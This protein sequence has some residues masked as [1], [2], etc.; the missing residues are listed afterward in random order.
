M[1]PLTPEPF[2][3]RHAA[4][5]ALALLTAPLP[6]LA[7]LPKDC[8]TGSPDRAVRV[9]SKILDTASTS[10]ADRADAFYNRGNAYAAK[11]DHD[12]AIADYTAALEINARFANAAYNRGNSHAAKGEHDL[13][14]ADYSLMIELNPGYVNAYFNR[15]NSHAA[16]GQHEKA[17]ADYGKTVELDPAYLNAW[18]NR[19]NSFAAIGEHERA[20]EDYSKVVALDARSTNAWFNR[21]NSYAALGQH[22]QAIADYD[23]TVRLARNY[24]YAYFNRGNSHAELGDYDKAIAD[25]NRA[26]RLAPKS[27]RIF[28]KRGIAYAETDKK[29]KAIADF[30]KAVALAAP[31]DVSSGEAVK[32]IADLETGTK[33]AEATPEAAKPDVDAAAAVS[34]EATTDT[35]STQTTPGAAIDPAVFGRRVAL[36]IG[37]SAYRTVAALPNAVA[38]A[39]LTAK[40]LRAA[41]FAE[42]TVVKDLD[43]ESLIAAL[44]DFRSR[45]DEADWAVVYYA[46]HG[47]EVAGQNF[48]IP[49]DAALKDQRDVEDEAVNLNRVLASV[50]GARKLRL[51]ALD[52]CRDNPFVARMT[53]TGGT[54]SIG[55]GLARVE[56]EGATV[57]LFAAKEGTTAADGDDGN[58]PFAQAFAT[59]IVEPGVEIS[60]ALRRLSDDVYKNTEQKQEPVQYG[61]LPV[62]ELYFVPKS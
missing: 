32:R 12:R 51:V 16:T 20:I 9:C 8:L 49:I 60:L 36:V 1:V 61:R 42:V 26:L 55:R 27:A 34:P 11:G 22:Q 35:A 4:L 2:T 37:N 52:A 43:R 30:R 50:E 47:I 6:A 57:V 17:I 58:S 45:T 24:G 21:G 29:D 33:K 3:M 25:Y 10:T 46:G 23:Q 13:A 38:D 19:G 40:A 7:K 41:G 28:L 14:I 56:P 5:L 39:D 54:R 53:V 15:G 62:E 44:R 48:L 31:D 59:R 18:Y